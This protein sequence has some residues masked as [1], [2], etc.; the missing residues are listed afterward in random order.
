MAIT[1]GREG[2]MK[3]AT[4]REDKD[5]GEP[6]RLARQPCSE[7]EIRNRPLRAFLNETEEAK[8]H[9]DADIRQMNRHDY[10]RALIMGQVTKV[11]Y[12]GHQADPRL[13]E[14]LNRLGNNLNQALVYVHAD[15]TRQ[16]DW[17]NLCELLEQTLLHVMFGPEI[18]EAEDV[19]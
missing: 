11:V 12:R 6:L 5:A 7:D 4:M 16:T 8:W 14:E 19:H 15:T 9:E 2:K 18:G 13:I 17:E 10:I 1:R 3:E